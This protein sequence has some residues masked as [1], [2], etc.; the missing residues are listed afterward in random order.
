MTAQLPN[1]DP[2][3][4]LAREVGQALEQRQPLDL[5]DDPL[6]RELSIYRKRRYQAVATEQA[7]SEVLWDQISN[8]TEGKQTTSSS[9]VVAPSAI[10]WMAAAVILL[11]TFVG[12][13]LYFQFLR[14]PELIAESKG[15]IETVQLSDGSEVT[16]RPHSKLYHVSGA[17]NRTVYR[18]SGEAYFEVISN[19]SRTFQV[20][21]GRG[22][23]SVLG[24][25]FTLSS[26]GQL[27]QVFLEE[28][29]IQFQGQSKSEAILLEPGQAAILAQNKPNPIIVKGS[30]NEFTD[31]LKNELVFK[32]RP[33]RRIFNEIEQ[34]FGIHIAAP[35]DV[36]DTKLS[37]S[38]SL[39]D[40]ETT[41]NY[42]GQSLD[43]SFEKTDEQSYTFIPN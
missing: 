37:G 2:D 32:N 3:L 40:R 41:L 43:C 1:N 24:T 23:V 8:E 42:L 16:L 11:A 25:K 19:P 27:T 28:G 39:E 21:A 17:D 22:R 5:V 13:I 38:L 10:R 15:A 29:S 4:H 34:H 33:A 20:V 18:L 30:S 7:R 6:V 26:W 14:G 36:M 9:H 31:W 35:E 12:I